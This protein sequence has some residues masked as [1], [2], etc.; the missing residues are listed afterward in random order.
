MPTQPRT[1]LIGDNRLIAKSCTEPNRLHDRHVYDLLSTCAGTCRYSEELVFECT[2][3]TYVRM[4]VFVRACAEIKLP[5][6]VTFNSQELDPSWI[7]D[8][9]LQIQSPWKCATMY[10]YT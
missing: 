10:V 6:V 2:L 7:V 4:Y 8:I 9:V 3:P 5:V 1:F